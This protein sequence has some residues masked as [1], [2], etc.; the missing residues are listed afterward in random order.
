M[1]VASPLTLGPST[2]G[3]KRGLA[4][5]PHAHLVADE[6]EERLMKRRRFHTPS[7][8]DSLSEDFSSQSLFYKTLPSQKSVFATNGGKKILV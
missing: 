5:S 8:I 7:E 1:E 6:I 4:C 3:N 2:G